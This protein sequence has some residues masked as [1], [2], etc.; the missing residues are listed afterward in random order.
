MINCSKEI[1]KAKGILAILRYHLKGKSTSVLKSWE[2]Y[3]N[4]SFKIQEL[5]YCLILLQDWEQ[6][7]NVIVGPGK[8]V[9]LSFSLII[10]WGAWCIFLSLLDIAVFF[11]FL[12]TRQFIPKVVEKNAP[13]GWNIAI[14][15]LSTEAALDIDFR[16]CGAVFLFWLLLLLSFLF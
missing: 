8:H 14:F 11:I 15:R 7:I 6:F 4:I 16:M 10:Y 5:G 12:I 1:T 9:D 13:E 3:L 2:V